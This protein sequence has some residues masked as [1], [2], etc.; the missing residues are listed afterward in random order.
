MRKSNTNAPAT[1]YGNGSVH[2]EKC[3]SG[4]WIAELDGTRRRARSQAQAN[5]KLREL[6]DRR[7][8]RL[9][10]T[11]GSVTV[12]D[13]LD[14]WLTIYCSDLKAKTIEGYRYAIE[15]YIK[16]YPLARIR[17][18]ELLGGDIT[19]WLQTLRRKKL[20]G[21]TIAIPYRRLRTA[22][23]VARLQES[24]IDTNPA[25]AVKP[26]SPRPKHTPIILNE[27]ETMRL[28][29]A[30]EGRRLYP[31]FATMALTGLRP[32]ELIGLRW[33]DLDLDARTLHVR[34]QLQWL[35]PDVAPRRPVWIESPKTHS[36]ERLIDLAPELVTV[37]Q[38][39]RADQ[40]EE[41]LLLGTDWRG[42]DYVFTSET[43]TPH[44]LS[45]LRRALKAALKHASLPTAMT[46]HDMRHC[47]GS[48]MLA[49][50]EDITAVSEVLGHSSRAVTEKIYA[51]A[52]RDRKKR[53]GESLG[54]LLRREVNE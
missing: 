6:Q 9:S 35:K 1:G 44:N 36:G 45:N 20:A 28:L 22:L 53:A 50:G 17:L 15:R 14:R 42:G 5:E 2:E 40:R 10:L 27:A 37:L 24:I 29:Q 7:T 48:L 43:G 23:E 25:A 54:F 3:G 30:W 32:S 46:L 39:W 19:T 47:A 18:E 4:R 51:H 16:P 49:R 41:R 21:T 38:V 34:G 12:A 31:L 13:W 8:K 52:L 26:P 33:R 11:K